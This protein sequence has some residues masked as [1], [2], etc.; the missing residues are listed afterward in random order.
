VGPPSLPRPSA[1]AEAV[2]RGRHGQITTDLGECTDDRHDIVLGR[3]AMLPRRLAR[4]PHLRVYTALPVPMSYVLRRLLRGSD[5]KRMEDGAEDAFFEH[6]WGR[7]MMPHR[8]QVLAEA[9]SLRALLLTERD[10]TLLQRCAGRL[11]VLHPFQRL[12]PAML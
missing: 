3:T 6:L 7:G 9:E 11:S 12:M 1:R 5:A 10:G 4:A 8:V 2:E